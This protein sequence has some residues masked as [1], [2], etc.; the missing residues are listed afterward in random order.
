MPI[1]MLYILG[2]KSELAIERRDGLG[3]C[4]VLRMVGDPEGCELSEVIACR[5]GD[6]SWALHSFHFARA[7]Y[8]RLR[9][10]NRVRYEGGRTHDDRP[11]WLVEVSP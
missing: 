3:S 6:D 10:L 7:V 11:I 2:A 4:L 5:L 1:P 8:Q 9:A